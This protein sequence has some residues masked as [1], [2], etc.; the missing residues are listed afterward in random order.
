MPKS[1]GKQRNTSL[2][3]NLLPQFINFTLI[4]KVMSLASWSCIII[5]FSQHFF[6][7]SLPNLLTSTC[8]IFS[9]SSLDRP[10]K[11]KSSQRCFSYFVHH[12]G[13][14]RLCL[15]IFIPNL[16]SSSMLI[17]PSQY[18]HFHNLHLQNMKVID[19]HILRSIQ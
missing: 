4:S 17:H 19:R 11:V 18:P 15:D 9:S 16:I 3:T 1:V 13:H 6:N 5:I 10:H 14:S 8:P 2:P 12:L 7:L